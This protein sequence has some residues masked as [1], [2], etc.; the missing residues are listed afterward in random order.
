[1]PRTPAL[2]EKWQEY[3]MGV[4]AN[5]ADCLSKQFCSKTP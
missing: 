4:Y 5:V 1:M 2:E 3:I